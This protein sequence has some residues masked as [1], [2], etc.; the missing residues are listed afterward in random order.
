M[1]RIVLESLLRP[2]RPDKVAEGERIHREPN[3]HQS[4][5]KRQKSGKRRDAE[6]D[7]AAP[8]ATEQSDSG[9]GKRVDF[10]A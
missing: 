9:V 7:G 4:N 1:L 2:Q 5:G 6:P 3:R 10:E 8:S